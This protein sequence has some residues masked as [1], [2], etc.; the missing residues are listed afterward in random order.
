MALY[1]HPE[2]QKILWETIHRHSSIESIHPS[3]RTDWFKSVVKKMYET[4]PKPW[5]QQ[6]IT[7]DQLNMINRATIK[8]MINDL[9]PVILQQPQSHQPFSNNSSSIFSENKSNHTSVIQS[10]FIEK[11]KE[12]E[13]FMNTKPPSEVNF[14]IDEIDEP[15][16]NMEELIKQ[17]MS[18][19]ELDVQPMMSSIV[20]QGTDTQGTDTQ[21]L[22]IMDE[23]DP[24]S[25]RDA[26]N[27]QA[28]MIHIN[29]KQAMFRE[30]P[31]NQDVEI[32]QMKNQLQ[33]LQMDVSQLKTMMHDFLEKL[34]KPKCSDETSDSC[35]HGNIP[36]KQSSSLLSYRPDSL[37]NVAEPK[38]VES[39][40]SDAE[41]ET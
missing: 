37:S 29:Q 35:D 18:Q 3:V 30:E 11:Q 16:S 12:M 22:V 4:I 7:T 23:L 14:K 38:T 15:I 39:N 25:V 19:R 9:K 40:L 41:S 21:K 20:P 34:S 17:H 5:F 2:N 1:I 32:Q 10:R 28:P 8:Y 24:Q 31:I 13:S 6:K 26:R 33:T 36:T 27:V